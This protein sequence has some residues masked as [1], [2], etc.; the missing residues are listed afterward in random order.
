MQKKKIA[1]TVIFEKP[2]NFQRCPPWT[3]G[4]YSHMPDGNY[5]SLPRQLRPHSQPWSRTYPIRQEDRIWRSYRKPLRQTRHFPMQS[6]SDA[7]KETPPDGFYTDRRESL[8]YRKDGET[9]KSAWI[10]EDDHWYYAGA[11]GKMT[12]GW[13]Q[14]DGVWYFFCQAENWQM[15]GFMNRTSGIT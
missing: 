11:N 5:A 13:E 2:R 12:A 8:Y 14:I 10:Y 6:P 3:K 15:D 1:A 9:V 4:C 7:V